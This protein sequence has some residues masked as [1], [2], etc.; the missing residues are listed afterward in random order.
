[1]FCEICRWDVKV[2]ITFRDLDLKIH[3]WFLLVKVRFISEL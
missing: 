1:M 2:K 3:S